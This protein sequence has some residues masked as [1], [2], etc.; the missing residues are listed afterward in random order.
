VVLQ[1]DGRIVVA[2]RVHV[3][4]GYDAGVARYLRV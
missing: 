4:S 1:A 2:G 3:S